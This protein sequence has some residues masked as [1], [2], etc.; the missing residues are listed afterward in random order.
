MTRPRHPKR[1]ARPHR[2]NG[3]AVASACDD[4]AHLIGSPPAWDP[5]RHMEIIHDD[6]VPELQALGWVLTEYPHEPP[7]VVC[8]HY[9]AAYWQGG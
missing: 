5:G 4:C 2:M 9:H 3:I 8:A 1:P 6:H 7:D